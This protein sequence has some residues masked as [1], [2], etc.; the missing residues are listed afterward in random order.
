MRGIRGVRP[1][2][3]ICCVLV[4]TL[5]LTG[6]AL[7]GGSSKTGVSSAGMR[8]TVTKTKLSLAYTRK[9]REKFAEYLDALAVSS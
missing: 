7:A 6:S 3:R 2:H 8:Y 4:V 9:T 5:S 1:A